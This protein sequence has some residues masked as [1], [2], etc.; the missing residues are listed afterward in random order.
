MLQLLA[1]IVIAG[2]FSVV[3]VFV[4]WEYKEPSVGGSMCSNF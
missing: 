2:V 4:V 1:A 3:V